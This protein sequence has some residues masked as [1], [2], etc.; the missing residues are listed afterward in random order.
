MNETAQIWEIQNGYIANKHNAWE[1]MAKI[2][3]VCIEE[4]AKHIAK[5]SNNRCVAMV[6]TDKGWKR[7]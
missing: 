5:I 6:L 1:V 2:G 7:N 3:T 4:A